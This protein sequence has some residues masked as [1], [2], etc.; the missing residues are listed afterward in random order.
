MGFFGKKTKVEKPSR[1]KGKQGRIVK[2]SKCGRH[3]E[4]IG[5][6]FDSFQGGVV[7]GD[8][9]FTEAALQQWLGWVC[10]N[11]RM[12]YCMDCEP[13]RTGQLTSTPPCPNCFKALTPAIAMHLKQIGKL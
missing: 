7:F 10:T 8:A 4:P 9:E 1:V 5:S 11:C 2:C 12:I 6:V 13:P 3:L